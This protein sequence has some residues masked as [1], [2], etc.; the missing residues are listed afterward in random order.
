LLTHLV[1]KYQHYRAADLATIEALDLEDAKS[2]KKM[3]KV[4][5]CLCVSN[6]QLATHTLRERKAIT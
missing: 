5:F 3:K 2:A 6:S 4:L 1:Y